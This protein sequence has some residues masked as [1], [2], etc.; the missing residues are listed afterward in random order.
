MPTRAALKT[1]E[2]R[3]MQEPKL[4][5]KWNLSICIDNSKLSRRRDTSNRRAMSEGGFVWLEK[6]AKQRQIAL[7]GTRPNTQPDLVA[8]VPQG[9]KDRSRDIAGKL[10][11]VGGRY[12]QHAKNLINAALEKGPATHAQFRTV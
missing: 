8:L 10:V 3:R 12:V 2:R 11:G 5:L 9:V 4:I 1:K 7:A 6:E